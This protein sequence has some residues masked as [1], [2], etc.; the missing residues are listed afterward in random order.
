MFKRALLFGGSLLTLGVSAFAQAPSP[1]QMGITPTTVP[2]VLQVLDNTRTWVKIGTVDSVSHTFTGFSADGSIIVTQPNIGMQPL[3]SLTPFDNGPLVSTLMNV[4]GNFASMPGT[5]PSQYGG[6]STVKFPAKAGQANTIYFLKQPLE[7]SRSGQIN[8]GS[9]SAG[10]DVFAGVTLLFDAGVDGVRMESDVQTPDGGNAEGADITGCQIASLGYGMGSMVN[11]LNNTSMTLSF[12]YG[13]NTP[14]GPFEPPPWQAGDGI[15]VVASLNYLSS[16]QLAIQPGAYLSSVSGPTGGQTLNFASPFTGGAPSYPY[17]AAATGFLIERLPAALAYQV[18][19]QGP[20]TGTATAAWATTAN[21]VMATI[22]NTTMAVSAVTGQVCVGSTVNGGS[23]FANGYDP[24]GVAYTPTV[25]QLPGGATSGCT[26]ATGNYTLSGPQTVATPTVFTIGA[27][28]PI[29]AGN[30]NSNGVPVGEGTQLFDTNY[31]P[32]R[33]VGTVSLC[34]PVA[35]LVVLTA[36]PQTAS[37]GATDG[38][39]F[40]SA[41]FTI[42]GGGNPNIPLRSG[43]ALWNNAFA[44]GAVDYLARGN[45]VSVLDNVGHNLVWAT[46]SQTNG[47]LWEVPTGLNRTVNG[48]SHNN[49]IIGFPIGLKMAGITSVGLN[50]TGSVDAGNN[51]TES[52]LGKWTLGSNTGGSSNF[53]NFYARNRIADVADLGQVGSFYSGDIYNSGDNSY[54]AINVL[55][56]CGGFNA[57]AW[58]GIYSSFYTYGVCEPIGVSPNSGLGFTYPLGYNNAGSLSSLW[59][60][61]Q[62]QT[63]PDA[64]GISGGQFTGNGVWRFRSIAGQNTSTPTGTPGSNVLGFPGG[65]NRWM[66]EGLGISD[67]TNPASIPAGTKIQNVSAAGVMFLSNSLM[68]SIA[69]DTLSVT[70]PTGGA[71]Q[72]NLPCVGI[73]GGLNPL[74]YAMYFDRYCGAP[75]G[76]PV[77]FGYN[78]FLSAYSYNVSPG[79]TNP[80]FALANVEYK[81]Y[82][83]ATV[84]PLARFGI[85]LSNA[86]GPGTERLLDAGISAATITQS[87]GITATDPVTTSNFSIPLSA[88][89]GIIFPRTLVDSTRGN[90]FILG[91]VPSVPACNAAQPTI[92]LSAAAASASIGSRDN[93]L[94][95]A[96]AIIAQDY[97]GTTNLLIPVNTCTGVSP[98]PLTNAFNSAVIGT[99]V[100]CTNLPRVFMPLQSINTV[101]TGDTILATSKRQGDVRINTAAAAGGQGEWFDTSNLST[102]PMNPSDPISLDTGGN[103]WQYNAIVSGGT[104]PVNSGSCAINTQVGGM[105]TGSFRAAGACASNGTII[106]SMPAAANAPTGW[107]CGAD[108]MTTPTNS[109]KETAYTPTSITFTALTGLAA[110]DQIAFGPCTGF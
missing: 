106:L 2:E 13:Q 60:G 5:V 20:S 110:S 45:R 44:F 75:G 64:W 109:L 65:G 91:T 38:L 92:T 23:A 32:N 36:S 10:N 40:T 24:I 37:Q 74:F 96:T 103:T 104:R 52:L 47:L 70:Q 86:Q 59:I 101:A 68:T 67:L 18:T 90:N 80:V 11:Q 76:A 87:T 31:S 14:W 8:C 22:N 55:Q 15:I 7:M 16:A 94:A 33:L 50:V 78:G 51:I 69:G 102:T 77:T 79:G 62:L 84:S 63:P 81:G 95:G 98:G 19:T 54:S 56:N 43:D 12:M 29:T 30:C 53:G 100:S 82:N 4:I 58:S 72:N 49:N 17:Y 97:Y 41:I 73:A 6:S 107:R 3:T 9:G 105:S 39:L 27:A 42:N 108:D 35:N 88:C 34:D 99:I 93:L 25:T 85:L 71:P 1:A 83:P 48:T 28:I 57:T 61:P 46:V 26:N 89:T 21:Q 66:F